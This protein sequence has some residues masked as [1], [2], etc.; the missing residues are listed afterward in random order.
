MAAE[1]SIP[2]TSPAM[3]LLFDGDGQEWPWVSAFLDWLGP[4]ELAD[5]IRAKDH[6]L[7]VE[8]GLLEVVPA[9]AAQRR[10]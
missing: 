2:A 8:L 6:T 1:L 4:G 3:S 10:G 9:Y 5:A 7:A